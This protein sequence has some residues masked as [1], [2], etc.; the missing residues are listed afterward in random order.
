ML[1]QV[2]VRRLPCLLLENPPE[3]GV[4]QAIL[5][6]VFA[7]VELILGEVGNRAAN[8]LY[9]SFIVSRTRGAPLR[10]LL[11]SRKNFNGL[12]C[13]DSAEAEAFMLRQTADI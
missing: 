9:Q 11:R 13:D 5:L 8:F 12:G 4:A 1:E 7:E 10:K 3:G 6:S 2:L